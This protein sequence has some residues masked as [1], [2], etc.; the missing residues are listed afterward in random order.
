MF[1]QATAKRKFTI[2]LFPVLGR[3]QLMNWNDMFVFSST[4]AADTGAPT[5]LWQYIGMWLFM[6]KISDSLPIAGQDTPI[7]RSANAEY[8]FSSSV[9][10]F[11]AW[12]R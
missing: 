3:Q 12:Q 7:E 8:W 11:L 4:S 5:A 1:L 9:H 6:T 10:S 2:I